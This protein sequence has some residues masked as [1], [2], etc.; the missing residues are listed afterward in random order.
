[1]ERQVIVCC[2]DDDGTSCSVVV[3]RVSKCFGA[4]PVGGGGKTRPLCI[5]MQTEELV[6]FVLLYYYTLK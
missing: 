2:G 1:M 5:Q 3:W 6:V 4:G